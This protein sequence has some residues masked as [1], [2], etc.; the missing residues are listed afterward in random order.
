MK[1]IERIILQV[2]PG[3]RD[4]LEMCEAKAN[5]A[6]S[7]AATALNKA[8]ECDECS[9]SNEWPGGAGGLSN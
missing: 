9:A 1:L 2:F 4:R 5:W 3:L 8:N 7:I 6:V